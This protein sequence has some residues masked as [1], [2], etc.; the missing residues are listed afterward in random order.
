MWTEK[1]L[2]LEA[3]IAAGIA[4]IGVIQEIVMI[5]EEGR[6][7]Q[8]EDHQVGTIEAGMFKQLTFFLL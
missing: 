4:H 6:L 2:V 5:E 1:S 8:E 3:G 7:H